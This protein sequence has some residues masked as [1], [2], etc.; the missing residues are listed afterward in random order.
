MSEIGKRIIIRSMLSLT[1]AVL[2]MTPARIA[3]AHG[4]EDHGDQKVQT[5][6][7]VANMTTRA[8]HAG[9]YEVAIKYPNIVPDQETVARIFITRFDT[10]EP[11]TKAKV[12]ML[13][14]SAGRTPVEVTATTTTTPGSYEVKLPPT[15]Q[16]DAKLSARVETGGATEVASFGTV[17][18][19]TPQA[20]A[21]VDGALW[22]RT[23][24]MALG[25]T[26]LACLFAALIF[27][28]ISRARRERMRTET[29]TA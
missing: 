18:V 22:A 3:S 14:E 24:L 23:A 27:V 20:Q 26:S 10:N 2:L 8:V 17:K 25:L 7:A 28:A 11:I 13:L 4:G 16:G 19:A 5:V 6:S 1:A 12:I 29:A 15:P 21:T 9:D